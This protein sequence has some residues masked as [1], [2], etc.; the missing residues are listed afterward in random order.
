MNTVHLIYFSPTGNTKKVCQRIGDTLAT[1]L[2]Y[3]TRHHDFTTPKGRSTHPMIADGDIVIVGVPV[4]AGRVPNLMV[5]WLKELKCQDNT[6]AI[7][8]VTYGNRH[9]DD[10]VMEL[11]DI[12]KA[13]G[14]RVIGAAAFIGEHSFSK[15]LG[16]GR[17]NAEDLNKAEEFATLCMNSSNN[18]EIAI[19]GTPFPYTQH[20]MPR[21]ANGKDNDIRKIKPI[22]TNKCINCGLCANICPMGSISKNNYTLVEGICIKCCAC[23]KSCPVD[24][25]IFEAEGYL[26]HKRELEKNFG[27]EEKKNEW[28]I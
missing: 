2:S 25:K 19:P 7:A 28:W 27:G 24:A 12:L 26:Y 3:A 13:A 18:G 21:H 17:P 20:Y 5:P 23:V 11:T 6:K 15:T 14:A 1:A 22:T 10:A 9:Y 16:A 4:Y 8:V